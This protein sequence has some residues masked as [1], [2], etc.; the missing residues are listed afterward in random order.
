MIRESLQQFGPLRSIVLDENNTIRAG[1]G[2]VEEAGQIGIEKIR[3]VDADA[4]EMIAVRRKGLSEAQWKSYAIADN[5]SSDISTW[6]I[7]TL[8]ETHLEVPL[9][10]WFTEEEIADW[11]EALDDPLDDDGDVMG[12][13]KDEIDC[14]CPQC[15]HQ[16]MRQLG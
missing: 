9:T 5:R 16:F 2:T 15:G 6:D 1:N 3:V 8:I 4:D 7:P 14:V 11:G 13:G 10:D 12:G